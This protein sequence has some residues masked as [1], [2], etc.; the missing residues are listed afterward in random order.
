MQN[1]ERTVCGKIL[2]TKVIKY[3]VFFLVTTL[4]LSSCG[5]K[6]TFNPAK[7]ARKDDSIIRVYIR[8]NHIAATK[9]SSGLYYQILKQGNG[10]AA[11]PGST[12]TVTYE[13][14]TPDGNVFDKTNGRALT[15]PLNGVI[16]GWTK[17][18]PLVKSG[19]SV[20]L[21]IPSALG[22]G[23]AGAGSIPANSVLIFKIDLL[24]V[25]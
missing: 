25:Q 10:I 20:L 14:K 11:T 5:E 8:K 19:G 18:V 3:L 9:D 7:Q 6:D 16:P 23:N 22:Y 1:E 2:N 17:G 21:L 24:T 13:G 12:V 15:F 4:A